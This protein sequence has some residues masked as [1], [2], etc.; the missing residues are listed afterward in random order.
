MSNYHIESRLQVQA[1][2]AIIWEA[3]ADARTWPRWSPNDAAYLE[4]EGVPA[5]D[6]VGARRVFRT[7]KITVREEVVGFEP[8][9]RLA[10]RLLSGLPVKDYEAE[11]LLTP[12][13]GKDATE[14]VWQA[15]FQPKFP[16]T[17]NWA[18]RRLQETIDQW[19]NALKRHAER[20][21]ARSGS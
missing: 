8:E 15:T 19:A 18:R 21:A 17:G 2:A 12:R 20:E 3:L 5:P 7:G 1:P 4:R 10:Y 6:G 13:E 14:L 16:L 9:R 11:V